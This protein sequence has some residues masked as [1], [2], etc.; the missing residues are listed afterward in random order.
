[1]MPGVISRIVLLWLAACC[2]TLS[3]AENLVFVT[4]D[5]L[6]WQEV[7]SGAEERLISKE[8]GGVPNISELRSTF[9]RDTP[10]ARRELL[11]PF[12]W[13]TVVPQGQLFGD[14]ARGAQARLTN[15]KKFSY[16]GYNE[17]FV[18]FADDRIKSNDKIPNPNVNVLEYLNR[19]PEFGGRVAAFATWD[20]IEFI[21]NRERSGLFIQLG[22]SLLDDEPLTPRQQ[23]VNNMVRELPRLWRGNAYDAM[24]HQ[25]AVEYLRKHQPRVLYVGLGE[26]D[27]WAHARRYDLYLEAAQRSDRYLRELWELLQS[28]PEYQGKTALV[29][30]TD[31]G[32]GITAK[33]WISHG[34]DVPDAEYIWIGALGAGIPARGVRENVQTTQSQIA[35]TLAQLVGEDF[36]RVAPQVAGPLPFAEK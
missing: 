26:T 20:V 14:P 24:T 12:L 22:W 30:T 9:W 29:V 3:A 13:G 8:A 7:F 27:E 6:R 1:M 5:G 10:E 33:D 32:R 17:M 16:P 31:H 25:G 34:E 36:T 4:W 35:A 23:Q 2:A 15:G 28:M 11:L 18:G 19:R 21:L